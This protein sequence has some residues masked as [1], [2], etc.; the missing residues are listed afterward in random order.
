MA[1][2]K[3]RAANFDF[4]HGYQDEGLA[5]THRILDQTSE[6]D[7]IIFS[8]LTG[9]GIPVSGVLGTAVPV[10][11]RAAQAW[12][13]WLNKYGSDQDLLAT[14]SWMKAEGLSNRTTAIQLAAIFW[15]RKSYRPAQDLWVDWLGSTPDGYPDLQRLANRRFEEEPSGSPFDWAA[16][17]GTSSV[18]ILRQ[19]GLEI[20][21]LGTENSEFAGVREFTTVPPG[22]YEFA[23]EIQGEGLSTDEGPHFQIFNPSGGGV[24][25]QSVEIKGD[26]KRSWIRLDFLVPPGNE[27]LE[28]QIARHASQRYDNKIAG[29]LRIYQVSLVPRS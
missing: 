8:Y 23:A 25:V 10:N 3:V 18:S 16:L 11:R 1:P 26:V 14:W 17:D 12:I 4:V 13:A 9:L 24:N 21:F 27:A 20:Q 5:L 15:D 28:I 19:H 7:E 29:T 2:V 6:F 22:R